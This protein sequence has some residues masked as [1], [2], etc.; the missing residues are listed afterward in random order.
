MAEAWVNWNPDPLVHAFGEA[1]GNR[2]ILVALCRVT[3]RE[4]RGEFDPADPKA[5]PQCAAYV[6]EGLTVQEAQQRASERTIDVASF[7]CG[8]VIR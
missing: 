2:P 7:K 8:R 4:Q 6:R 1:I 3:V 5:C